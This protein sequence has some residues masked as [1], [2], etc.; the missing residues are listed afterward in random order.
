VVMFT[1]ADE[2][3][4]YLAACSIWTGAGCMFTVW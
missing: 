2:L 3:G 4:F 1:E